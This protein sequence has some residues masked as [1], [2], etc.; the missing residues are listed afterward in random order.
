MSITRLFYKLNVKKE[1]IIN[2]KFIIGL[3]MIFFISKKLPRGAFWVAVLKSIF[4]FVFSILTE[5]LFS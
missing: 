5:R 1:Y 3:T 2:L 4:V